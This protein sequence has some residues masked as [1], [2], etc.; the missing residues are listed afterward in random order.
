MILNYIISNW[1][2][3][4]IL[5]V[6]L[7]IAII[8][9][10]KRKRK[11]VVWQL[12]ST[13]NRKGI[14]NIEKIQLINANSGIEIE[15]FRSNIKDFEINLDNYIKLPSP[16]KESFETNSIIPQLFATLS[17]IGIIKSLNING[18]FTATVNPALLTKFGNGTI[19]TMIHGSNGIIQNAGFHATSISVFT[20]LVV[21]QALSLITGQYYLNGISK[22]LE[23]IENKL[24]NLIKQY[25][26]KQIAKI[27]YSIKLI[28]E[29]YKIKHP[30]VEDMVQLKKVDSE[31]SMIHEEY[32]NHISSIKLDS[33]KL[34][35]KIRTS[36]K[37]EELFNKLKEVSLDFSTNMAI[38]TDEILHLNKIIELIL[39]SRMSENID[40]RAKRV[41]EIFEEIAKWNPEAFYRRK[42]KNSKLAEI[43]NIAIE[44][45]R[46][47]YNNAYINKNKAKDAVI[48]L[49]KKHLELEE[50]INGKIPVLEMGEEF[51]RQMTQ[52]INI[53]LKI[54]D[55]NAKFF[56]K[57]HDA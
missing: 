41:D 48:D 29:L 2:L 31:I 6:I 12:E 24:E 56:V 8:S 40:N 28:R 46:E 45:A 50:S 22:Q 52:P 11:N 14:Q 7:I 1:V 39:N 51:I 49:A 9:S 38:V 37:I 17:Q 42:L 20:P 3:L 33:I 23:G 4:L 5:P 21:L 35:N 44:H 32:V 18:L 57:K 10:L 25:R 36:K 30:N 54:E 27:T 55:R 53:L 19:S 47:I 16:E 43:Y 13:K 34:S 26:N 15:L